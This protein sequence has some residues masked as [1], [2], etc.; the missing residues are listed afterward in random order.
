MFDLAR[1]EPLSAQRIDA[2]QLPALTSMFANRNAQPLVVGATC[3][4]W[5]AL[6][7]RLPKP[8]LVAGYSVGEVSALAVAGVLEAPQAISV[9]AARAEWMDA[10][11][12]PACP[13]GLAAVSGVDENSLQRLLAAQGTWGPAPQLCV[14]VAIDNGDGHCIVGGALAALQLLGKALEQAGG[15][16][17]LLPIGVASHTSWMRDAVAPLSALLARLPLHAPQIPILTGVDALA[18][19]GAAPAV[20]ALVRQTANQIRWSACMDAIAEAGINVALELGPGAALSRMLQ[21]RHPQIACRAASEFRS[22][23]AVS[24]WVE[25]HYPGGGGGGRPGG[26]GGTP[27]DEGGA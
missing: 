15:S 12:D 11:V 21:R 6:R 25:R 10:C 4:I 19:H 14:Q 22:V 13:Q 9:A 16:M 18:V 23:D 2:W 7:N 3:A 8:R 26:G 27:C 20:A 17:Q 24:A 1:R 5:E